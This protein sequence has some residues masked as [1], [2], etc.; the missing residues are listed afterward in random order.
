[1]ENE[2]ITVL[3]PNAKKWKIYSTSVSNNFYNL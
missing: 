3:I 2:L 1:M